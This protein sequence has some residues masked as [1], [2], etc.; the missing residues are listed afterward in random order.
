MTGDSHSLIAIE[1]TPEQSG[2]LALCN[3][4]YPTIVLMEKAGVF[5]IFNGNATLNFDA[6][7]KL[8]SIKRELYTYA[9]VN[10]SNP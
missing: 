10:S 9:Q 6:T 8:K 7:G 4:H 1:L 3:Q 5:Q 2:F